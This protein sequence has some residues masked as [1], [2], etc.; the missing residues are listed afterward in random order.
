MKL[1]LELA[2]EE[3]ILLIEFDQYELLFVVD[4]GGLT[5]LLKRQGGLFGVRL[6]LFDGGLRLALEQ[7]FDVIF[8]LLDQL[9]FG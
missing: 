2:I 5:L 1:F 3:Y 8:Q 4:D 7:V 9:G 6:G